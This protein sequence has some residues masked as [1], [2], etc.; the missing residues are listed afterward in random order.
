MFDKIKQQR[1]DELVIDSSFEELIWMNGFLSGALVYRKGGNSLPV[2]VSPQSIPETKPV[3]ITIV[4]GTETGNAKSLAGKLS[5]IAKQKGIIAK[6]TSLDQYRAE[7]L[8]KEEFLFIVI[9]TQGDGEPPLAA[10]KFYDYIHAA[11][12]RLNQLNYA[13]IGLGDSSYPQFCQTGK[14]VDQ[15]FEALGARR[16]LPAQLCDADYEEAATTWFGQAL[17]QIQKTSAAEFQPVKSSAISSAHKKLY[18]GTIQRAVNLNDRGSEKRTHH[19]EIAAED[20]VY[21]PGDSLGVV[22]KNSA[23]T[24]ESMLQLLGTDSTEQVEYRNEKHSLFELLQQKLN[25]SSLPARVVRKYAAIVGQEI[26]EVTIGL[27]DLL[28]IYPVKGSGQFLEVLQILEPISPR[29][30]SIAS[31][32][33]AHEGEVH[34][35]VKHDEFYLEDEKRFGLC[36]DW[37]VDLDEGA[38]LSFY[39]HQNKRFRLPATNVDMIMI[40]AGTGVA[41]FRSFIAERAAEGADGRNWLLFGDQRFAS[42]FLYQTE[43]QSHQE[44]GLLTKINTAFSRD[45]KEKVYVQHKLYEEAE[46]VYEWLENGASVYI[47]GARE[48]MCVDVEKTLL[49]IISE[50]GNKSLE[51]AQAYLHELSEAERYLKDVY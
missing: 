11:E 39:I 17:N 26:P 30:Y 37:L 13:V 20:V 42:D 2:A 23:A 36:S 45:Q 22:P 7:N 46:T 21:L 28:S 47:C 43:W 14:D 8:S 40:G 27:Y 4:F 3:K 41:P 44:S 49:Q 18:K 9:S 25:I 29:L 38:E 5:A 24:V 16:I 10:K 33:S 6:T 31:S 32:P 51:E 50:Q 19:I 1:L 48:Q 34:I 35:T 12:I 15:R